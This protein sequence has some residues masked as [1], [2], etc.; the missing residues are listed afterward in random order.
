VKKDNDQVINLGRAAW[1]PVYSNSNVRFQINQIN[2]FKAFH[3]LA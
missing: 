3:A 1:A 2:E